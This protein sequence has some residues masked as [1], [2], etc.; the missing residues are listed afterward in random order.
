MSVGDGH[1]EGQHAKHA[2]PSGP[3]AEHCKLQGP[4]AI[5]HMYIHTYALHASRARLS[6]TH[7]ARIQTEPHGHARKA[8]TQAH[9]HAAAARGAALDAR[10]SAA[11]NRATVSAASRSLD[12]SLTLISRIRTDWRETCCIGGKTNHVQE[13]LPQKRCRKMPLA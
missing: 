5:Q 1:S 8:G 2:S 7:N 3:H 6:T 12:A 4:P 9:M 13:R 11:V 10:S